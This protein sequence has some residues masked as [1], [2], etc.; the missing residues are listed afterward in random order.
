MA[1]DVQ[2]VHLFVTGDRAK[3]KA[4]S[5]PDGLLGERLGGEGTQCDHHGD[6]LHVP[7]LLELVHAHH[8]PYGGVGLVEIFEALLGERVVVGIVY[9]EHGIIG[10]EVG[11]CPEQLGNV[12]GVG[13]IGTHHEQDGV[14][15]LRVGVREHVVLVGVLLD[16]Q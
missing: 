14:D 12:R 15:L 2:G 13:D 9:L 1:E 6:G 5:A 3:G 10:S 7:A 8:R 11:R 16:T 4:E